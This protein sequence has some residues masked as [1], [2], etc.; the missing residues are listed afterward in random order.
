MSVKRKLCERVVCLFHRPEWNEGCVVDYVIGLG[1]PLQSILMVESR[2]LVSEWPRSYKI[3]QFTSD[4]AVLAEEVLK[5]VWP[6][7]SWS[8]I[9]DTQRELC[10]A[11]LI[12]SCW[13]VLENTLQPC[14]ERKAE[15][16]CRRCWCEIHVCI[17]SLCGAELT[18]GTAFPSPLDYQLC[19]WHDSNV[20]LP[21]FLRKQHTLLD[22]G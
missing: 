9:L 12:G 10:V 8:I 1:S 22:L 16:L 4:C 21:H 13:S 7:A 6:S 3:Q 2:S 20:Y 5:P 14:R 15:R 17:H 19:V 18:P 11:L